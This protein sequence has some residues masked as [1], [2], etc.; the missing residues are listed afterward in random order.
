MPCS[1]WLTELAVD[2]AAIELMAPPRAKI[3]TPMTR[4]FGIRA[5]GLPARTAITVA[6]RA[7]RKNISLTVSPRAGRQTASVRVSEPR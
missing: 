5:I 7:R 3:I 6:P 4:P 1:V 2:S